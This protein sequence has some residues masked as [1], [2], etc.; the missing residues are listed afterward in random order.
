MKKITHV[1]AV[2]A[3]IFSSGYALAA[4][5]APMSAAESLKP[6]A[7]PQSTDNLLQILPGDRVLGSTNAQL[8]IVEY[9]SLSCSHCR[10]F[11]VATLPGVIEKY[12]STNKVAVIFRHYPLNEPA[13]RG[14]MV[15][16]C[17]GDK[18]YDFLK[19]LF[20]TQENWAFTSNPTAA[21]KT[22]AGVGGMSGQ[23]F[24]AC[25]ADKKQE[26]AILA[27]VQQAAEKLKVESTPTLFVGDERVDGYRS[28][29]DFSAIIDKHLK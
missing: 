20:K 11:H 14:A 22:L 16:N 24:D 15:A 7:K 4:E 12:V 2:A 26:E 6:A 13:L 1:L 10:D 23:Q 19:V 21:L 29:E 17:A 28:L 18:F 27:S 8:L 5:T 9:A 3:L 25:I